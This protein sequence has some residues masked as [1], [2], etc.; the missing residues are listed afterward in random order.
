MLLSIN[1]AVTST[2]FL[3]YGVLLGLLLFI[4]PHTRER[5]LFR[6]YLSAMSAWS[7]AAFFVFV[8]IEHT[9]FWFRLMTSVATGSMVALFFFV[10]MV[11]GRRKKWAIWVFWY[12][13]IS[14]LFNL[15]TNLVVRSAHVSNGELQYS[16]SF[17][18]G[19]VAGPGY[20]LTIFNLVE[21]IQRY[22]QTGS[23]LQK[24]RIRYLIIGLSLIICGSLINWTPLGKYPMD[25]AANGITALLIAY[26]ILR[27][28]LLDISVVI[29]KGLLYS[30]PTTLIGATYFLV[31]SLALSLFQSYLGYSGINIFIL[32]LV[33]AVLT[34]I[35][36][37]PIRQKAQTWIDKIF[38]RD[39][40]DANL[41][42]QRISRTTASVL[43]L[44]LVT[45]M[46]LDE[47]LQILHIKQAAFFIRRGSSGEYSIIVSRGLPPNI[48]FEMRINHP[49]INWFKD[50]IGS[51]VL[52]RDNLD[53][54]PYFKALWEKE[55]QDIADVGF[56]IFVP[57]NSKGELT[58]ILALG[59]KLSEEKYS[60]DD[61]QIL[62]TLANQTAVAIQNAM[63]FTEVNDALKREQQLNE[64]ARTLSSALDLSTILHRV[65]QLAAEMVN[66]DTSITDLSNSGDRN[67]SKRIDVQPKEVSK[68][69][70]EEIQQLSKLVIETER[71]IIISKNLLPIKKLTD[72]EGHNSRD[73]L[74]VPLIS[75]EAVIGS[76]A[77][78]SDVPDKEFSLRDLALAESIGR[79]A[80]VAIQNAM[81]YEELTESFLQTI[82]A[83][84]N[85]IEVRDNYTHQHSEE[86]VFLAGETGRLL[87]C[88]DVQLELIRLGALL[89]DIGKIGVPDEILKKPAKLT[90][91]E[92]KIVIEH[93]LIGASIVSPIKRLEKV[94]PIIRAHHERYDGAGYPDGLKGEKIPLEARIL[95]VTDSYSAM[96]DD[97]VYRK[98]L[99]NIEAVA[100]LKRGAG[101]QFDPKVVE[102]L[103][104]VLDQRTDM[105]KSTKVFY[106][107][108][109]LRPQ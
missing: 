56:D 79:L 65:T 16:F 105:G 107:T 67:L 23:D 28:K 109:Q 43:D 68:Q 32:S 57:L 71:S 24:N 27:H 97:R 81:L 35:I 91:D 5:V 4:R 38:F 14:V 30:I 34:A 63:L 95:S 8:D 103:L 21:L 13:V 19:L 84:A 48:K 98:A 52:T 47:V 55:R 62:L 10:Q 6:W 92:M 74:F 106:E 17:L 26:A 58:G 69:L 89:H 77:L 93:P 3:I 60:T 37:Q 96:I 108:P 46:I 54:I 15:F 88:S 7:A 59:I 1:L 76:L 41:M 29:R 80:G 20:G 82:A 50:Q 61:Q 70:Q 101:S 78:I 86:L 22:K 64:V 99:S 2:A 87:G 94:A 36:V 90:Q 33:V 83:L 75:G 49:I 85:A 11:V 66:A 31:I 40:Y 39:K 9:Y 100:E 73:G 42:L 44:H 18:I 102:A 12:G 51:E 45:S 72:P 53:V 25:I 104:S